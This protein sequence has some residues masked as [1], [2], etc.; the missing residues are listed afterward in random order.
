MLR[1]SLF[2]VVAVGPVRRAA[3][4]I[5][6]TTSAIPPRPGPVVVH[7]RRAGLR[8]LWLRPGTIGY[9]RCVQREQAPARA[10]ACPREY[11]EA[12]LVRR[13]P[14]T[15]AIHTAWQPDRPL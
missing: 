15:P 13:L 5:P 10:A 9:D 6:T 11:A 14:A 1:A 4:T 7:G 2:A 8:R 12:Q 3:P